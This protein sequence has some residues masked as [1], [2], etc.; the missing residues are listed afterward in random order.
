MH[1]PTKQK[2]LIEDYCFGRTNNEFFLHEE[3]EY[4][5][6]KALSQFNT[7]GSVYVGDDADRYLRSVG[8]NAKFEIQTL[9]GRVQTLVGRIA[10]SASGQYFYLVSGPKQFV[11]RPRQVVLL[12]EARIRFQ[13]MV[14][15]QVMESEIVE[16]EGAYEREI[17][18]E[19]VVLFALR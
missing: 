1:L 5:D 16:L 9:P 4:K 2:Q 13:V 8:E 6:K 17:W 3:S 19:G 12:Q 7:S 15:A 14:G 18:K 11:F 10:Y